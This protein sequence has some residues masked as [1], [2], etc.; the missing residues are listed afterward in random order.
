MTQKEGRYIG[1]DAVTSATHGY[2]YECED[3]GALVL[4][5][6]AHDR[7]HVALCHPQTEQPS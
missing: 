1:Y 6:D 3:C 7:F 4:D 5:R 2:H